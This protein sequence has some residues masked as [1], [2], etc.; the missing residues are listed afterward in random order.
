MEKHSSSVG[1]RL[2][3]DK[4]KVVKFNMILYIS[5][6]CLSSFSPRRINFIPSPRMVLLDFSLLLHPPIIIIITVVSLCLHLEV[7]QS[8]YC[9]CDSLVGSLN[10]ISTS[11]LF[12]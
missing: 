1:V 11:I 8:D 10:L 4:R 5:L 9:E 2:W 12:S 7:I 3:G 6:R